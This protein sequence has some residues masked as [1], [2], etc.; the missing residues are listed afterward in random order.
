VAGVE[1]AG[2]A[3]V[4][5][6]PLGSGVQAQTRGHRRE[7]RHRRERDRQPHPADEQADH[8]RAAEQA[9]VADR[10]GQRHALRPAERPGP[11]D[12][13][14]E[15]VGQAQPDERE[16]G[17]RHR[18]NRG[19]RGREHA[20]GRERRADNQHVRGPEGADEPPARQPGTGHRQRERGVAGRRDGRARREG[21]A[22]VQGTPV[23][24]RAFA[25]RRAAGDQAEDDQ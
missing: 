22:E 4:Q 17:Q 24:D 13:Q 15:D 21:L 25:V 19:E 12:G 2:D 5:Q 9:G 11:G 7:Q 10:R 3:R 6:G 23:G 16:P 14:R 18:R 1:R 8:R 20:D